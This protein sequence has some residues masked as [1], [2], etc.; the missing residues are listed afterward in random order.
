MSTRSKQKGE[1]R[2]I[3]RCG[4]GAIQLIESLERE[5]QFRVVH[6]PRVIGRGTLIDVVLESQDKALLDFCCYLLEEMQNGVN[7]YAR[8][9]ALPKSLSTLARPWLH[10]DEHLLW[11]EAKEAQGDPG[12]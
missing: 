6:Q 4:P 11:L 8:S 3:Q 5:F 7:R 1:Q 2:I 9:W 10:S 12:Y